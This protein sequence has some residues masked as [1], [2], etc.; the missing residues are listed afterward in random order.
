MI[1]M[2]SDD[3]INNINTNRTDDPRQ[4]ETNAGTL[5]DMRN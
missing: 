5:P 2:V 4:S 1:N 3:T